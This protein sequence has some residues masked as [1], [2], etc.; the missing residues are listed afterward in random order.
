MIKNIVLDVGRVLVSWEWDHVLDA[1]GFTG[2][3]REAV[4]NATVCSVDWLQSDLSILSD[5]EILKLFI[6]N[7]PQ[8]EAEIRL[9]WAHVPDMIAQYP[10]SKDWIISMKNKGYQ[11]YILSNYG[12]YTYE[13]TQ[14]ALFCTKLADGGIFSYEVGLIKP[15]PKIYEELMTRYQLKAE[16]CVFL[17]DSLA[18]IQAA[19]GLGW[20]GIVFENL[21]QAN[22]DLKKLGVEL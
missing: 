15:D 17:D 9:L 13:V 11:V 1:L 5:E 18:N 6:R 22:E 12:R 8:Y 14:E 19:R 16:E 7:A 4:V 2:E 21:A 3:R 10:Y 20:S